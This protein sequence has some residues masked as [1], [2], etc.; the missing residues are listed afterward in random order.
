[1]RLVKWVVVRIGKRAGVN[2]G[3]ISRIRSRVVWEN[4]G[5]V[6]R[7]RIVRSRGII[8]SRRIIRSRGIVGRR[9]IVRSRGVVRSRWPRYLASRLFRA[10]GR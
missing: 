4:R 3:I 8:G 6:G 9:G 5:V 10:R 1:M 7:S 2:W